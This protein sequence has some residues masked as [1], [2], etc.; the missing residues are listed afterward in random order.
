[1]REGD[2]RTMAS[3][4]R[5]QDECAEEGMALGQGRLRHIPP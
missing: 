2:V 5:S 1:V 3:C 4:G